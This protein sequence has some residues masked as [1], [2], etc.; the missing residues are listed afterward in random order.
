[1]SAK[2][3]VSGCRSACAVSGSLCP[4][5]LIMSKSSACSVGRLGLKSV[6]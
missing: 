3:R 2:C 4:S 6:C 1:M 5:C